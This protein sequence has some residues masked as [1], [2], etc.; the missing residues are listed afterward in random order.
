[1]YELLLGL[2]GAGAVIV[3]GVVLYNAWQGARVRRGMPRPLP[4]EVAESARA[5]PDLSDERPFIEP[6]YSG[7]RSQ[8]G[9]AATAA[10]GAGAASASGGPSARREPT[11]GSA[12]A[13]TR[14]EPTLGGDTFGEM[15][16]AEVA[17]PPLPAEAALGELADEALAVQG[18]EGG[19]GDH[20]QAQSAG[21]AVHG[22][23][24]AES[25]AAVHAAGAQG[26]ADAEAAQGDAS[27]AQAGAH[28]ANTATNAGHPVQPDTQTISSAPPNGRAKKSGATRWR[29]TWSTTT[30]KPIKCSSMPSK[31]AAP[32]ARTASTCSTSPT[33][34]S[35]SCICAI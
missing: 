2:I 3:I 5:V 32:V 17:N 24:Q 23:A 4:P 21:S 10:A 28:A 26:V 9:G 25:S 7:T 15:D 31:T 20:A 33:T 8:P 22:E 6:A 27:T 29:I 13:D 16:P 30:S 35:P 14:R 18:G 12:S 34:Y 11:F 19:A 1:M